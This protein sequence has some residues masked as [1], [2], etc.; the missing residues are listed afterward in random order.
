MLQK[1]LSDSESHIRF[2]AA[3]ALVE[4]ES[5]CR[6]EPDVLQ[7]AESALRAFAA[8]SECSW[9]ASAAGL[10]L[11]R[12]PS[13]VEYRRVLLEELRTSSARRHAIHGFCRA[14]ALDDEIEAALE[15]VLDDKDDGFDAA[16]ALSELGAQNEACV[17]VLR[18]GL[19]A[20][21]WPRK[22]ACRHLAYLGPLAR[23]AVEQLKACLTDSDPET[24]LW[25]SIAT[26]L[27]GGS[28]L[29]LQSNLLTGLSERH[30]RTRAW[31]LSALA[32]R[33]LKGDEVYAALLEA[34]RDANE[35]CR[36]FALLALAGMRERAEDVRPIL[37]QAQQDPSETVRQLVAT[38]FQRLNGDQ[39]GGS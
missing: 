30:P 14:R 31:V 39:P 26:A 27:A 13:N 36:G 23:P 25:A 22:L 17:P 21:P 32:S 28:G 6:E 7:A 12:E 10:L 29:H 20:G 16:M 24:R 4:G 3:E 15:G 8:D 34:A 5:H 18:A 19:D 9:R 37:E 35:Q 33:E 38:A 1:A 11:A 2:N